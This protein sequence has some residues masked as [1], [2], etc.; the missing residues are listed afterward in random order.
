MGSDAVSEQG[1]PDADPVFGRGTTNPGHSLG[2]QPGQLSAYSPQSEPWH[3]QKDFAAASFQ[4]PAARAQG[5]LDAA[6]ASP[7]SDNAPAAFRGTP[8]K[9]ARDQATSP[10]ESDEDEVDIAGLISPST[11]QYHPFCGGQCQHSPRGPGPAYFV[12]HAFMHSEAAHLHAAQS[13]SVRCQ[14]AR[15][16]DMLRSSSYSMQATRSPKR[17]VRSRQRLQPVNM[18][19]I[20]VLDPEIVNRFVKATGTAS[21]RLPAVQLLQWYGMAQHHEGSVNTHTGYAQALQLTCPAGAEVANQVGANLE[22]KLEQS[23]EHLI[24]RMVRFGESP[25]QEESCS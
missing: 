3:D 9:R 16:Y 25:V 10:I 19:P 17:H 2:K 13:Y 23:A 4:I 18:Q 6:T 21:N 14:M 15:S 5:L 1:L 24:E 8:S 7:T 20:A 11:V 12:C 22:R